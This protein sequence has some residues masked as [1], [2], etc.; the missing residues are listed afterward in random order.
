MNFVHS[1]L[2]RY[3]GLV[4]TSSSLEGAKAGS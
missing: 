4:L 2:G 1:L 3:L